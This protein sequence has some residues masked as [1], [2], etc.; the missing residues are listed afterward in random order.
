MSPT[1]EA[2]MRNKREGVNQRKTT[3]A[4]RFIAARCAEGRIASFYDPAALLFLERRDLTPS[5]QHG[6]YLLSQLPER[7]LT[8]PLL[9]PHTV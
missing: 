8:A 6:L 1:N 3:S 5:P 7:A 2:K 4:G 9:Q